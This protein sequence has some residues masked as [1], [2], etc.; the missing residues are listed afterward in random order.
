MRARA[1]GS[2][3]SGIVAVTAANLLGLW[4]DRSS[5]PLKIRARSSFWTIVTFQG[6]WWT[7][8]TILVTRFHHTQPTYDWTSPGFGAAFGVYV[9]LT[10]GF[11]VNY[12]FLY[13]IIN[14]LAQSEPQII[15][16][17][18]LLRGTESALQAISY[19][20]TSLPLWGQVGCV[21]L[22][23]GLW[24]VA[25]VPVWIV[26]RHVGVG[27]DANVDV[28]GKDDALSPSVDDNAHRGKELETEQIVA[29]TA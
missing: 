25:I 1:L 3:V 10:I 7:W 8:A 6:G 19:G 9:F 20:L 13:F 18:A 5:V 16:Y 22:N 29:Q 12:L 17:A 21:Y 4:L 28:E 26:L 11:Q 24:G 14:N 15:R 2:F 23:F 27:E